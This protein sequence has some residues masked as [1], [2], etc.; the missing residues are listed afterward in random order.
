VGNSVVQVIFQLI[1]VQY[2]WYDASPGNE[3]EFATTFASSLSNLIYVDPSGVQVTSVQDGGSSPLSGILVVDFNIKTSVPNTV[4]AN[5]QALLKLT[6]PVMPAMNSSLP[7]AAIVDTTKP[8]TID[9]SASS[10]TSAPVTGGSTLTPAQQRLGAII[11]GVLGGV[12]LLVLVGLA[13]F[14]GVRR[15]RKPEEN[16]ETPY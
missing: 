6:N 8:V 16:T 2:R 3:A 7:A 1:N 5:L 9:T 11:G 14:Y 12:V 4:V 13:V 10:V 15:S